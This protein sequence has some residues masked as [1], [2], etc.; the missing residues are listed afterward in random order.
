M[1]YNQNIKVM[2]KK[3]SNFIPGHVKLDIRAPVRRNNRIK[4]YTD[5]QKVAFKNQR[6]QSVQIT[7]S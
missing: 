7:R 1:S 5:R 3:G 2:L 6:Q 4:Q